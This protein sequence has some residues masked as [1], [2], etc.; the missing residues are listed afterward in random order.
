MQLLTLPNVKKWNN[1]IENDNVPLGI[2]YMYDFCSIGSLNDS[3]GDYYNNLKSKRKAPM[4]D[5]MDGIT[6][7]GIVFGVKILINLN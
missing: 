6:I 2:R 4:Q 1:L 7:Y 5:I 3:D